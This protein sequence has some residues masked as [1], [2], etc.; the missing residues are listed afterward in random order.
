MLISIISIKGFIKV[1]PSALTCQYSTPYHIC[2]LSFSRALTPSIS[3][4]TILINKIYIK[5]IFLLSKPIYTS[6]FLAEVSQRIC[7]SDLPIKSI[8]LVKANPVNALFCQIVVKTETSLF[9]KCSYN[10]L[11]NLWF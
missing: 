1:T 6:K 3:R 7:S 9:S 11:S 8:T 10:F 5:T 2:I 4:R